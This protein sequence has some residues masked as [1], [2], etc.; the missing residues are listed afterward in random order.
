MPL[1]MANPGEVRY[2]K[3]IGGR[4]E[5]KKFLEGLGFV[6][7]GMVTVISVNGGNLIVQVKDARIAISRE[8][9]NK[10]IV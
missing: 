3:R 4:A 7:G 10:I 8:M 5:T 1:S 6:V 9:A 2:I